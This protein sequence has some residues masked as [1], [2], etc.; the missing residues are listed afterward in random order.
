MFVAY[1]AVKILKLSLLPV[2]VKWSIKSKEVSYQKSKTVMDPQVD[3][4]EFL[5]KE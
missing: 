2:V 5:A 4:L 1:T 3:V